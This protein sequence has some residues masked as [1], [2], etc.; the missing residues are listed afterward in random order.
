MRRRVPVEIAPTAIPKG[1]SPRLARLLRDRILAC[2]EAELRLLKSTPDPDRRVYRLLDGL[3]ALRLGADTTL[4]EIEAP[5]AV[6]VRS[7][8]NLDLF[9]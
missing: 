6:S 2:Q 1:S 9:A 7:T 3:S 5:G 8:A 4:G